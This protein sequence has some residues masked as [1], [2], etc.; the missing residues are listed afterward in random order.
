MRA[1]DLLLAE[2]PLRLVVRALLRA[3]PASPAV[4]AR[5]DACARPHYLV[6]LLHAARQARR[7]S[8]PSFA[9]I[10]FGVAGGDGLLTLQAHAAAVERFTGI[11]IRLYGFDA[12]SGLPVGTGDYRDHPDVWQA[13]DFAT[14][15]LGL[16]AELT[17]RTTLVVGDVAETVGLQPIPEP[18]GFVVVD[19]DFYSST[20][21]ALR[22]LRRPDVPHLR[23]VAMYFDDIRYEFSY[24]DAG[25]LLAIAE[26]NAAT[27]DMKI[28][29]WRGLRE[30][31]P[32]A[33]AAWLSGM[34]LAHDLAAVSQVRT[35][36]PTARA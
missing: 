26:F 15:G 25:E 27:P 3:L 21:D 29:P 22:I 20:R 19:L 7:E 4:K 35:S 2:P 33:E 10:E 16:K 9:A 6:G 36:R 14:D 31:R 8:R 30:N 18:L 5:W 23:H 32:F 34:Y 13:G 28:R 12:G 11:E 17:Q 1:L 24:E